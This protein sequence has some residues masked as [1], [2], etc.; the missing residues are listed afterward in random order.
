MGNVVVSRKKNSQNPADYRLI[1]DEYD[2]DM[3]QGIVNIPR[4]FET[5]FGDP[6]SGVNYRIVVK[7]QGRLR[8]KK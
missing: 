6:G 5:R 3:K 2:F 1:N 4:N 8:F 7:N